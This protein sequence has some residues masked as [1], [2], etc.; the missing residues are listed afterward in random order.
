MRDLARQVR[1]ALTTYLE[2]GR[3]AIVSL[4]AGRHDEATEILRL[5]TAAFHNFRAVDA[6]AVKAGSD[7]A[8]D[9]EVIAMWN[10]IRVVEKELA[11]E[12][13]VAAAKT[14]E[15][16]AK[17]RETRAKIGRYRSGREKPAGFAKT[18]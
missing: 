12:L 7:L 16:Y 4:K 1:L 6:L 2:R 3:A 13:Q 15:L 14:K 5:R 11:A 18:V 9:P 10:E 17:I 8:N